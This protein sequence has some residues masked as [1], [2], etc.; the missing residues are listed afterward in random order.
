MQRLG[1]RIIVNKPSSSSNS[2]SS[3]KVLNMELH[4]TRLWINSKVRGRR[5]M[6]QRLLD[7]D[8]SMVLRVR[9]EE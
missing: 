1:R 8:R 5:V 9:W 4:R 3:R 2:S 7:M 6:G